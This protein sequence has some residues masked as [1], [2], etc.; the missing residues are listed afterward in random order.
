MELDTNTIQ[1]ISIVAM[2]TVGVIE[3]LK[4]LVTLKNKKLWVLVM[5]PLSLLFCAVYTYLPNWVS[6][7]ILVIAVCQMCWDCILQNIKKIGEKL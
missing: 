2:Q 1:M 3:A 6:I 7:G 5:M 4:N